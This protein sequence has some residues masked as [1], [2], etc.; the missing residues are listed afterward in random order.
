M[1][2]AI[3][4]VRGAIQTGGRIPVSATLLSVPPEAEEHVLIIAAWS[5][6]AGRQGGMDI[7]VVG[8]HGNISA[9]YNL[10]QKA[11]A[12]VKAAQDGTIS[13]TPP[14]DPLSSGVIST[15]DGSIVQ[16]GVKWGDLYGTDA[17][18]IAGTAAGAA[19][20]PM[21]TD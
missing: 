12:W 10:Y 21:T 15:V 2:L 4:R 7:V 1:A 14:T 13:P 11:E 6:V 8:P 5:L 18:Y 20:Y 17:E 16:P 9:Y 3:A 19:P